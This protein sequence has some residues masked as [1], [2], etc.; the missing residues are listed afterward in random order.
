MSTST[1]QNSE[2]PAI[3][4][5]FVE[6]QPATTVPPPPG[7]AM[8]FAS[9]GFRISHRVERG[10]RFVAI[11]PTLQTGA[12]KMVDVETHIGLVGQRHTLGDCD[13]PSENDPWRAQHA[14]VL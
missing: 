2:R 10:R 9:G 6:P 3:R 13:W 12:V 11:M 14:R 1:S 7:R 5:R 4:L 8:Q